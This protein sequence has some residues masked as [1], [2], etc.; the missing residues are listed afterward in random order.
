M[1]DEVP[2]LRR[3]LV[4]LG[5]AVHASAPDKVGMDVVDRIRE[6][7]NTLL[8]LSRVL[9]GLAKR[10]GLVSQKQVQSIVN[11]SRYVP[12]APLFGSADDGIGKVDGRVTDWQVMQQVDDCLANLEQRSKLPDWFTLDLWPSAL[13]R[14][15]GG[16]GL[17]DRE[18]AIALYVTS[19]ARGER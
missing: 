17:S 1:A 16:H 15:A 7:D 5:E 4:L 13:R 3:L 8:V 14:A 18:R 19:V 9:M 11:R 6:A 2:D 12:D 10:N